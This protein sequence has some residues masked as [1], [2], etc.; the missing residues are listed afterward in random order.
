MLVVPCDLPGLP[1]DLA[2]RLV[3]GLASAAIVDLRHGGREHPLP[4]LLR[5]DCLS[6]LQAALDEGE[7]SLLRAFVRVGRVT[8][9]FEAERHYLVNMNTP[10]DLARIQAEAEHE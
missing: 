5:R 10:D 8:V 3:G 4:C 1:P 6:A 7:R 2:Q 9:D